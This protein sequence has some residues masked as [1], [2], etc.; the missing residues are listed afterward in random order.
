M[1]IFILMKGVPGRLQK[2]YQI[3]SLVTV[4]LKAFTMAKKSSNTFPSTLFAIQRP[5]LNCFR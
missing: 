3:I 5:V 1:M 4:L 2:L